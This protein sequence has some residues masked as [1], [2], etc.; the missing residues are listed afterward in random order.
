M[1][2]GRLYGI[3]IMVFGL[4]LTGTS[5]DAQEKEK[6]QWPS[7]EISPFFRYIDVDGDEEKFQEDWWI[8]EDG[9]GGVEHF[10]LEK[11]MGNGMS[12]RGE[13][14]IIVPEEDYELR[15][16]ITKADAWFIQGGYSRYRK[17]FDGT[18][19]FFKPFGKSLYELDNDMH[20]DIG[21]AS[22]EVGLTLPQWPRIVL[23]YE[24]RFKDGEKSLL[25]WG[26]VTEGGITRK[27][28]P[29]F[30]DIDEELNI[31]KADIEYEI[32]GIQLGD[33]FRYEDY[34]LDTN[35]QDHE[36]N[37]DSTVI[38][39]IAVKEAY[40]HDAIVNTF[41]AE[42]HIGEKI[43][44]SLGYLFTD[45]DGE[46]ALRISTI[47]FGPEFFDK[48]WSTEKVDI[49]RVSH[50]VNLNAVF[51]PFLQE[52]TIYGGFQTE[53]TETEGDT[54][55]I[56][57]APAVSPDAKVVSRTDKT[58]FEE[59][60]G[61]RYA[62]IPYTIFYA[63][64]R[65]AQQD[66]E[67]FE[68]ERED[69][70]LSFE[71]FTDTG[72]ERGRYSIGFNTSPIRR[73][74]LSGK[75]RRIDRDNDYDHDIDTETGYSAFITAQEL[76]T[77]DITAKLNVSLIRG[78]KLYLQYQYVSTDIDTETDT[79]PS[80]SV[81]SGKYR[82]NVYTTG[83]TATPIPRLYLTGLFS[84]RDARTRVFDNDS[85]STINYHG[86]VYTIMGAAGYAVDNKT[87]LNIEYLFTRSDNFKDNS[88]SGLPLGLDNRR[89]RCFATVSRS[90]TDHLKI[91]FRYGFYLYNEESNDGADDYTAHLLGGA[92]TM[93]F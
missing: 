4:L 35:R 79:V 19:G 59:T 33:Y 75:Y 80:S 60:L 12:I 54:D 10:T 37:L 77:D 67:L 15:L 76:T 40:G 64:G 69:G 51:G 13:G 46:A 18:G 58:A 93:S 72:V 1:E 52:I 34:R 49:D 88:S 91:S 73:I 7:G 84:Y 32:G 17:Y 48:N 87:D 23:G 83:A 45:I 39:D 62:G 43:Y 47:P 92:L 25:E 50:L 9:S 29:S 6:I 44:C 22:V 16:N 14:R 70:M 53:S 2:K 5:L 63:E 78:L 3:F 89:H 36:R 55:A 85:P 8:Q 82:A 11:F 31:F 71:R 61:I 21:N 28:F 30:K 42:S 38:K 41:H 81:T 68:R 56:L 86:D 20:L 24:H 66:I 57:T 90:I 27:I 26:G 74:T 65:W